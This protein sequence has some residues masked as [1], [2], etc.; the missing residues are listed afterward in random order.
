MQLPAFFAKPPKYSCEPTRRTHV[1]QYTWGRVGCF[2][3]LLWGSATM[4]MGCA[5]ERHETPD[6]H[7]LPP[8]SSTES[9]AQTP[10]PS[11]QGQ[12]ASTRK[13]AA[14]ALV[15]TSHTGSTV[16]LATLEGRDLAMILD[17]DARAVRIV[18]ADTLTEI[19]HLSL[20]GRPSQMVVAGDGRAYVALRDKSRVVAL[21]IRDGDGIVLEEM[22]SIDVPSEPVAVA[23]DPRGEL[24]VVTSAWGARLTSYAVKTHVQKHE[25]ALPREPRG[26]VISRDGTT[27]H[28]AHA[29]GS[30]ITRVD[31]TNQRT[32][33]ITLAGSDFTLR[34]IRRLNCRIPMQHDL[35]EEP[36]VAN[37]MLR[38]GAGEHILHERDAVQGFAIAM[39]ED[40]VFVPQ[41]LVHRG[42]V[43]AAGGYGG[44]SENFPA[45]QP[46]MAVVDGERAWLRVPNQA[47]SADKSRYAFAGG[48]RRDGC[49][50]PRAAAADPTSQ[51]V[52]VGCMGTNEVRIIDSSEKT[53]LTRGT[54]ARW[55]VPSGPTGIAVDQKRRRALVWSQFAG[56]LSVVALPPAAA[57]D[58]ATT[59]DKKPAP[60]TRFPR[61]P[62]PRAATNVVTLPAIATETATL[63]A[64]ALKGRELFHAAGD[65]RISADGRA[66]ASCHPDG[67]EDGLTWST[68]FG[69]RQTPMLA[70]RLAQ[71]TV[72]YGWQ[73]DA[74]TVA[75]HVLQTFRRL[76]GTGLDGDD[77]EALMAYC[78]EMPTPPRRAAGDPKL[79]AHGQELFFADS[80]G[81][82]T[83]HK[84]GGDSDGNRHEVGSGPKL[85]TPS[86]KFLAGTA[87][88]FHDGRYR[89]LSELL[90][91]TQGK[92]GWGNEL[93]EHDRKALEAF[94]LTL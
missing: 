23:T 87:P 33:E 19:G 28:V 11:T 38:S 73:G 25:V 35:T 42:E 2:A 86:L 92:M 62:K 51:T 22:A 75:A 16:Q 58:A 54:K 70:G 57:H 90:E 43:V 47:L 85:D 83:C 3:A 50:L 44:S 46:T 15:A 74:D 93:T 68:P 21:Q 34:P 29:V 37:P 64:A 69:L 77:L 53:S 65:R 12:M 71:G 32:T 27:A 52:L 88:Y 81:C 72:P 5:E 1:S 61:L 66:C 82:D 4:G 13:P 8:I 36:N 94:L 55:K 79:V 10:V 41:V 18:D 7:G 26:V 67:R 91:H 17:E 63:S 80:V 59:G 24:L 48:A 14:R 78:Q 49:F 89:T 84:E 6:G 45:H 39:L 60:A 9:A 30:R 20:A 31:L 40:R 76:G 56:K